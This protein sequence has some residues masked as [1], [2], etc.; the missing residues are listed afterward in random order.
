MKFFVGFW[1]LECT[2]G[3][4][5]RWFCWWPT[6]P[7]TVLAAVVVIGWSE[8]ERVLALPE[9]PPPCL[10]LECRPEWPPP[11]VPDDAVFAGKLF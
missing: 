3:V 7:L 1:L 2:L 5:L 4:I 11:M 10:P 9:L 8:A 6:S